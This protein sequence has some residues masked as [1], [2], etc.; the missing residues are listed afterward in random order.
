MITLYYI[1]KSDLKT[2]ITLSKIK[3]PKT[4]KTISCDYYIRIYK[5]PKKINSKNEKVNYYPKKNISLINNNDGDN[6]Y[7]VYIISSNNTLLQDDK[8]DFIIPIEID[9]NEPVLVDAIAESTLDKKIYGYNKAYPNSEGDTDGIIDDGGNKKDD[10][11]EGESKANNSYNNW[12][13][14]GLIILTGL[15]LFLLLIYCCVKFCCKKGNKSKERHTSGLNDITI[16][17]TDND[18]ESYFTTKSLN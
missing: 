2:N 14:L 9:T 4:N 6:I 5:N 3:N 13:I 1:I 8:K 7:A 10:N 12:F 18:E 17:T 11:K 15:L 16:H